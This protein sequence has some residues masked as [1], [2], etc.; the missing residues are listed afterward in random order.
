M[1]RAASKRA[2]VE[3]AAAEAAERVDRAEVQGRQLG[4]F[5]PAEPAA[6]A[7]VPEAAARGPGRPKGSR[8]RSSSRLR[9]W[10]ATRGYRQPEEALAE[11]AGLAGRG[12]AVAVAMARAEQILAWAGDGA[13]DSASRPTAEQRLAVFFQVW[14]EM[15]RA[16]DALLPYGLEKASPDAAAAPVTF[17]TLP[18]GVAPAQPG[19]GARVIDGRAWAAQASDYAPPPLPGE[20]ERNQS[21]DDANGE[22]SDG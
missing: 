14:R 11:L 6:A 8:N 12:D 19:D 16:M 3:Q 10:L 22:G 20:V 7:G 21:V 4:L 1:S 15:G 13:G 17:I 18:G 9:D 2:Q 5:A